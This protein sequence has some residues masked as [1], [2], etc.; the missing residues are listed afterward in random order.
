MR[1]ETPRLL[2]RVEPLL[3]E[4]PRGYLSRVAHEHGYP[5]PLAIAQIAGLQ[6]TNLERND[7][8]ERIAHVLRLEPEEWRAMC[9]RR[10]R[11]KGRYFLRSFC[12]HSITADA[13]N[14]GRTRVCPDCL[15]ERVVCWAVWD[16][17]L[18]SA[19]SKHRCYLIDQ[20]PACGRHLRWRR[21]SMCRCRCGVDLR[22][23]SADPAP[24]DLL[25]IQALIHQASGVTLTDRAQEDL[26]AACLAPELQRLE[27]GSLLRLVLFAGSIGDE[28]WLRPKQRPFAATDL[29]GAKKISREAAALF[30]EWPRP[31]H[32]TLR[33]M[34]PAEVG[35]PSKLN[36]SRIYG[37]FY[38]HLFRV[39]SDD[40][41]AFL[42]QEFE[43]FVVAEWKGLIRGNH[44]YFSPSVHTQS[45]W[46]CA[47]DA[48]KL[49][50]T[51]SIRIMD[52][53]RA[54]QI[55]G[56]FAKVST[57]AE[58]WVKRESLSQ[59]ILRRD[60]ELARYML[61]PEV[62]QAL[63]IKNITA[64]SI[65]EA[66]AIRHTRGPTCD[67]PIGVTYFLRE[68]V[69]RIRDAF[70]RCAAPV[71]DYV[72]PGSLIALR[73]AMKNFLGRGPGLAS[74][75]RAVVHGALAP[76]GR[77]PQYRGIMGYL[78]LLSDLRRYRPL[79]DYT[80]SNETFLNFRESAAILKVK[81][82]VVR[83]LVQSGVLTL[84]PGH[85]NGRSKLI[86]ESEVL[87]FA[88]NYVVASRRGTAGEDLEARDVLRFRIP[89]AGR[90]FVIF[91]PAKTGVGTPPRLV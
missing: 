12:G 9:Y 30:S 75:I 4:S 13:L 50:R 84:V 40:E 85:S 1:A 58:C 8:A 6:R 22:T 76:V 83:A 43:R 86:A 25:A 87:A 36:F 78:F 45:H 55:D 61:R 74:V 5:G 28:G 51:T 23:V 77:T 39:L 44:R 89:E 88:A 70:E 57:R 73:H 66:G 2:F 3:L 64:T 67:F 19:C 32:E 29:T 82:V 41:A 34:L 7:D 56:L 21:P 33:H 91:A 37:N 52:L 18:V 49:A 17:G 46:V 53:V 65:A 26:G 59:W 16:L 10:V 81:T 79:G 60:S 14:Y 42:R 24:R 90:G 54:R 31:F 63:G 62:E 48:E 71:C 69:M 80:D 38:R 15:R 27:L 72:K 20:C 47:H 35:D 11:D 68:D